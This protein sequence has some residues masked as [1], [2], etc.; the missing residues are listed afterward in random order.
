M[1]GEMVAGPERI[2]IIE[3]VVGL[4]HL[5]YS[6]GCLVV[7]LAAGGPG[8][9]LLLYLDSF[10]LSEAL[11]RLLSYSAFQVLQLNQQVPKY[12]G[13]LSAALYTAALFLNMYLA[14]HWRLKLLA[15][16]PELSALTPGGEGTFRRIFGLVS[17][18]KGT[19]LVTLLIFLV[20]FPPR[21]LIAN[22]PIT[23]LGTIII[24]PLN[25]LIFATT[26]WMFL[27]GLWALR[28]FSL[29]PLNLKR[30]YE[31]RI[32]GLRPLGLLVVSFASTFFAL[33][34]VILVGS[35]LTT[36][37][38]NLFV[39][40]LILSMG[41]VMLLFSLGGMHSKM[42]QVKQEEEA[43]LRM[44]T[45]Q[46]MVAPEEQGGQD[47]QVFLRMEELLRLQVLEARISKIPTWPFE[48]RVVERLLA[49]I[50]SVVAIMLA[51]F[52]QLAL[53]L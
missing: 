24:I 42:I 36:D 17:S 11:T 52:I 34:S 46:L 2:T 13:F 29:E 51:K 53:Q 16:G 30:F 18:S 12:Q 38:Y 20:Y 31:D 28:R 22:D 41:V 23:L 27:S 15:A 40:L 33:D 25:T 19:L 26:T 50:L 48:T 3:R 39:A 49:I 4:T 5:P 43:S 45:A 35:F 47:S 10:S 6:L 37:I 1:N 44:R 8:F 14:R 7:A 21:A 9:F 32:L